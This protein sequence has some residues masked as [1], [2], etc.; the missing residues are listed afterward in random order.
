LKRGPFSFL[1][2]LTHFGHE[3]VAKPRQGDDIAM[4]VGTFPERLAESRDVAAEVALLHYC[5][6]PHR[7]YKPVFGKGLPARFEENQQDIKPLPREWHWLTIAQEY[8]LQGVNP[9]WAE[10]IE[11]LGS[12]AFRIFPNFSGFLH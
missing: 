12:P 5:A 8:A 7:L 1:P 3:A 2:Y 9:E 11:G 4:L 10:L 6:R